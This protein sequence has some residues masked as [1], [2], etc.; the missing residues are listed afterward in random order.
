M[1]VPKIL[2]GGLHELTKISWGLSQTRISREK[3]NVS[4][5]LCDSV[6]P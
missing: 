4:D 6:S 3:W 5:R 2:G 1:I